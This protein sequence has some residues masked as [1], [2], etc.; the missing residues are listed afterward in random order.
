M[1]KEKSI[2]ELRDEKN[3][4]IKRGK[5]ITESAKGEKRQLTQPENDELGNI[6]IR[7]NEINLEIEERNVINTQSGSQHQ[8]QTE[9]RFSLLKAI[10]ENI[11]G[12]YS[13]STLKIIERGKA[14]MI[15]MEATGGLLIPVENRAPVVAGTPA[16]GGLV[17]DTDLFDIMTPLTASLVLAKAGANIV[18]GL[19]NNV[20]IPKYSGTKANWAGETAKAD[21]GT[22][23]FSDQGFTPKRLTAVTYISKQ[24]LA[25]D[26]LGVELM[27]RNQIVQAIASKLEATIFGADAHSDLKPDG[28]FTVLPEAGGAVDWSKV[29]G[30]ET[31]V[32]VANALN[33][34]LA[35]ITHPEILGKLKT[36]VKDP[37]GA[38]GFIIGDNGTRLNG[39]N[40]L[41]TTNV[42]KELQ[43]GGDEYGAIFGNWA[44]YFIGQWGAL[45]LTVDSITMAE[46]GQIKLV[47]NAYFDAGVRRAESFSKTT[48]K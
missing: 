3:Q 48:W 12:S 11:R 34:N 21:D 4:L 8:S 18:T 42:A 22:G 2:T 29:V 43:E 45:D 9:S 6:Q 15:G 1:A 23:T 28:F 7:M 46:Y 10:S 13:D 44:D 33:G 37:S 32:D 26:S 27:L 38:G 31:S 20:R 36:K 16:N 40:C 14:Q 35:Y 47:I 30:L 24:M 19:T 5:E 17:V 39:Y 41:T 25:Q